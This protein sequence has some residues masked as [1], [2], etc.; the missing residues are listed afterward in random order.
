[1]FNVA[2]IRNIKF[3]Y[4]QIDKNCIIRSLFI[5][6]IFITVSLFKYYNESTNKA[7]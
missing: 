5:S 1:M 7:N 2:F 6:Y 3:T 4:Y